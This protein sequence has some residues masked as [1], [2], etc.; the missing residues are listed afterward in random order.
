[1]MKLIKKNIN[2]NNSNIKIGIKFKREKPKD[3]EI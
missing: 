2:K 1:M 3:D